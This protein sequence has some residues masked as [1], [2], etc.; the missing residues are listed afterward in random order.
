[1]NSSE[2]KARLFS[3]FA[4]KF[5]AEMGSKTS[6]LF[7]TLSIKMSSAPHADGAIVLA[8]QV[9]ARAVS[10]NTDSFSRKLVVLNC[11]LSILGEAS[12]SSLLFDFCLIH[13]ALQ[14]Q[15][16]CASLRAS[17]VRRAK[18]VRNYETRCQ[19]QEIGNH[20]GHR[21]FPGKYPSC[22]LRREV[23]P[24]VTT[25]LLMAL[26]LF[27]CVEKGLADSTWLSG[28]ALCEGSVLQQYE[29]WPRAKGLSTWV[30]I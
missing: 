28:T 16:K 8:R 22:N 23:A 3:T 20:F 12:V 11:L 13:I 10:F 9:T 5:A 19:Y 27:P 7:A 2:F 18:R 25:P 24:L 29:F 21:R 6:A 26:L 14:S 17:C 30:F 4:A 15:W 1:M